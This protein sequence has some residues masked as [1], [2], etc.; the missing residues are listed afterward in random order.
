MSEFIELTSIENGSKGTLLI[1]IDN[2]LLVI[3]EKTGSR[4]VVDYLG[5]SVGWSVQETPDDIVKLLNQ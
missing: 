2:I 5:M 3:P 1:N 4:L